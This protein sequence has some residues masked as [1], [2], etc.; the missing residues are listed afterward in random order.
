LQ[1]PV[2]PLK[3]SDKALAEARDATALVMGMSDEQ[4]R[5]LITE[6]AGFYEIRCPNCSAGKQG[7]QLVWDIGR[8]G[9]LHCKFCKH[10]YPSAKYPMNKVYEHVAPT[11]EVQKYPYW[12]GADGFRHFFQAK[13]DF[14]ARA[15]A[16]RQA[17]RCAQAYAL[18]GEEAYAHRA[19]VILLRLAQVY[20][21]IPSHGLSDYTFRGPKFYPD[22]PPYAYLSGKLTSTWF[23]GEIQVP[24]ALAWDRIHDSTAWD[25]LSAK[26]GTDT[27][28]LVE[29]DLLRGMA[30]YTLGVG[31]RWLTNMTPS[32]CRGLITVGRVVGE[33]S[34]V[35]EAT[36]MLRALLRQDFMAD[37]MWKDGS[38]SYHC[39]TALGIKYAWERAVG[40]SDP[41]GYRW[42]ASGERFDDLDPFATEAFLR[43][44]LVAH[45]AIAYPD[46]TFCCVHDTW[47]TH[48]V[49][50]IPA[51]GCQF[52]WSMG[53]ATLGSGEG[54]RRVQ[55]QL[56]F[57]G[58]HGHAHRDPLNLTLWA[59]G[60]ELV[61][62][63]GYTHTIYRSYASSSAAHNIVVV[64][65][66]DASA[67]GHDLPWSGE[68]RV[69]MPDGEFARAISVDQPIAYGNVSRYQRTVV[70]VTR[71]DGPAYLVD[72]F[73][74]TGGAQ[75]DWLLRGSADHDQTASSPTA[76]AALEHTLLG[77]GRKLVP[78][79]NEGGYST[80]AINAPN[81][82]TKPQ[83]DDETQ[84][85]P[86]GLIRD[87]THVQS[88]DDFAATFMYTEGGPALAVHLLGAPASEYFLGTAPSIKRS[89]QNSATV[90]QV[91][92]P[93]VVARRAGDAPL[94]SRFA[95]VLWP[96]DGEG[97]RVM[98]LLADGVQVGV[99]V[100]HGEL[101]DLIIAP[102]ERPVDGLA[103]SPAGVE[104]DALLAVIR[105]VDDRIIAADATGG[106]FLRMGSW[107][108]P[109]HPV[110]TGK[111]T[112]ASGGPDARSTSLTV[113]AP[114]PDGFAAEGLPVLVNHANGRFSLMTATSLTAKTLEVVE[115]PDFTVQS[116]ATRFH[117]YPVQ[118]VDGTPTFRFQPT[119][120]WR[121]D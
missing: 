87:L 73:D 46:G 102:V 10:I 115:P 4:V 15:W 66:N 117:Y 16:M 41:P 100:R 74:V 54:P 98:P 49:P 14:Q 43:K 32:W 96:G 45:E 106:T 7:G 13:I 69:W 53:H 21:H 109:L 11:G 113:D 110:V 95:A 9:E 37:G 58:S 55:A 78:Y 23:Y 38:V 24:L 103:V 107:Q 50:P 112:A 56:H 31:R 12:E 86:Y 88:A 80:V 27:R 81:A 67:G 120:S 18:S 8:P 3:P 19:A 105:L 71:P 92:Q 108:M 116:N 64:D 28:E 33:P 90:D 89:N 119:T 39:Q 60:R 65:E 62:D 75:H 29:R 26:Y 111:I 5:I 63:L 77:P 44:C 91:R 52:L 68:L 42:P 1:H 93:I 99:E 76:M 70:M 35:H 83:K 17:D 36:D 101:R 47:P 61:S 94:T 97:P 6:Q 20:P 25:R 84:Y 40:Y 59:A 79:I 34:Y 82:N 48:K 57:S 30:D 2:Y 104:T 118:E 72:V 51:P 85:N 114:V 121:A 22:T